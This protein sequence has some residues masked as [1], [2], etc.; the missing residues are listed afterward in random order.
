M[1]TQAGPDVAVYVCCFTLVMLQRITKPIYSGYRD[2]EIKVQVFA[3]GF[4]IFE[5]GL[6][7][8]KVITGQN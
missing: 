8:K 2:S 6:T 7:E 4:I 3:I 5:Y 1:E